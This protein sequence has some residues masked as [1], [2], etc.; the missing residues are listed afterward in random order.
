MAKRKKSRAHQESKGERNNVRRD[1]L[2][3]A[4]RDYLSNSLEVSINKINAWKQGKRVMLTIPNKGLEKEKKPFIRVPAKD[5]WGSP[6][7]RFVMK[8]NE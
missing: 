6:G 7:K 3:A 8:N 4:R 5:V 1:I 2:K